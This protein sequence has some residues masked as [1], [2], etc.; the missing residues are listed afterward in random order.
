MMEEKNMRRWGVVLAVGLSI[1][2]FSV[3]MNVV[4][5]ALPVMGRA[6]HQTDAAMSAVMMVYSVPLTLLMLPAGLLITRWSPLTT[7]LV[8]VLGF[9]IA[10][11]ICAFAPSF[12]VLLIGRAVQGAFGAL[13]GSQ[14]MAIAT[15]AIEPHERGRAM[16][17][18]GSMGPLGAIAGPALGGLILSVWEWPAVFLV[19]IPVVLIATV[20][21]LLCLPGVTFG[22]VTRSGFGQ[23]GYLLRQPRFLGSLVILLAFSSASG[24]LSYLMPFV[25]Q[26][27]HH[28]D[29][30]ASGFIL[31]IPS[32][33]M[34]IIGPPGG[35]LTDRLG[36]RLMMPLGW[37]ISLI[38][39]LM[40]LLTI[41]TPTSALDL[42]WRLLLFGLGNGLAY[43]PLLTFMMSIGPRETL[44][45]ASALSNT[46]RQFGFLC[47]PALVSLLWSWQA[48]ASMATRATSSVLVMLGLGII[49]LI[50]TFLSVRGLPRT[51]TEEP[52]ETVLEP[53]HE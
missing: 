2:M 47:G 3:D 4:A 27:V 31:L 5:L 49:A 19:N 35:F 23:M 9:G 24:A 18:L 7:F 50:C 48:T 14:G 37:T 12:S 33:S 8:G 20:L 43:G 25:L 51:L 53:V 44:G 16:G 10:S 26:D 29:L 41:A 39:L 13:I 15:A 46:A 22:T 32:L 40:L 30:A 38:G 6:F 21:A 28:L 42:D 11:M 17:I 34:L 52:Q 45:A 36:V 1:I